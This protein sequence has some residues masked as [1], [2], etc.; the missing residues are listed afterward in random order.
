MRRLDRVFWDRDKP[1]MA[2]IVIGGAGG[3]SI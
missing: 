3:G 2:G 1:F